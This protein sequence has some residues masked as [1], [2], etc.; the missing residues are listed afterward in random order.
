MIRRLLISIGT[1]LL[2][3]IV[4]TAQTGDCTGLVTQALNSVDAICEG[5][6]R[7]NACYGASMVD[8]EAIVVPTP[9]DF[10]A[11][12]GVQEALSN[13][14]NIQPRPLNVET[15]EFG[16]S[17]LNVQANVPNSVPGQAVLFML[18]GDAQLTNEGGIGTTDN[19]PF[20][21][22]YF[23]PGVG[24]APCYEAEPTLTIQTPGGISTTL[25]LNG[26]ETE[27]SP[28]T[29][30]TITDTVCTIH[31]GNIIRRN[32]DGVRQAALLANESV[33]I[34][35]DDA[36]AINVTNKRAISEREYERGELIQETLNAIAVENGWQ[37]QFLTPPDEYGIQP[38][39]EFADSSSNQTPSGDCETQHTIASGETLHMIAERYDTSVLGIAEFNGL[40]NAR[41]IFPGDTL[42][43]PN[44]GSGFEPIP[45]GQ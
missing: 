42:C 20:Q 41:V 25:V 28:G 44:V 1:A 8:S 9:D 6:G 32:S 45:A 16:V 23:L 34:F 30:L 15:G 13:F 27:F 33:D 36:G 24:G 29:L 11:S 14:S 35:I 39:P 7:N 17:L 18:V 22:F 31:R 40:D 3:T 37:Q 12:P 5:L 21:S 19:A 2:I 4:A 43:I 26:V 10:F 38:V